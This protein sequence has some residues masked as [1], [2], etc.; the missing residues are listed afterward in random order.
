MY[1]D[2]DWSYRCREHILYRTH[3]IEKTAVVIGVTDISQIPYI[4]ICIYI[5]Y[6]Y[7]YRERERERERERPRYQYLGNRDG[8]QAGIVLPVLATESPACIR[9]WVLRVVT[10]VCS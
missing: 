3:S 10:C 8:M 5:I 2:G 1:A 9:L 7:I 4:Y 6:I